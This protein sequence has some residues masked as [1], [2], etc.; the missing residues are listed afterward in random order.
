MGYYSRV[1]IAISE[2]NYQKMIKAVNALSE[3]RKVDPEMRRKNKE[4]ADDVINMLHRASINTI[5]KK[6]DWSSSDDESYHLIHVLTW[7]DIKWY[8]SYNFVQFLMDYIE[9]HC[10]GQYEYI[11]VGE[12]YED[13]TLVHN[14]DDIDEVFTYIRDFEV[15]ED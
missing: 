5:I 7:T 9:N 10:D 15:N 1:G 11:N 14:L 6:R 2:D 13:I 4:T 12:D 3:N 8:P